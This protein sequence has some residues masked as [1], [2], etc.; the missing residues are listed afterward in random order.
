MGTAKRVVLATNNSGKAR[1]LSALLAPLGLEIVPQSEFGIP[2]PV[3]DGDTFEAN[4]LIKA[5]HAAALSGLPA[6]A[7]DS[8]LSVD[9][10][11]GAPGIH[12]ARYAG[13]DGN[14]PANNAKLIEALS[15]TPDD[16]RGASFVCAAVY[17]ESAADAKPIICRGEWRGRILN[18][19]RG[20]GGFG[21]D[22]LFF[23]PERDCSSAELAAEE[24]NRL[25]HRGKALAA[26]AEQLQLR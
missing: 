18:A 14:D 3:E 26:L 8:G 4:A 17:V 16:D 15:G 13:E 10:L 20:D 22:P 21:Y 2:S 12:S 11:D 7:D 23:V 19:P 1:E 24:K 5:R 6:I 25:S 9:A